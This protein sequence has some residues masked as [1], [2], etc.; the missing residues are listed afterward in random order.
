MAGRDVEALV[1]LRRRQFEEA[2]RRLAQL[3]GELARIASRI[4]A[5]KEEFGATAL[6]SS[7]SG[8]A[9]GAVAAQRRAWRALLAELE[10]RRAE[11]TA[12]REEAREALRAA[13][14]ALEQAKSLE[15]EALKR[16]LRRLNRQETAA[17][18]E[19]AAGR[20]WQLRRNAEGREL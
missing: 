20:F 4:A 11:V 16:R 12:L 2:E 1:S 10:R 17:I 13:H 19:L 8:L 3:N 9:L 7:G 15:A 14:V 5:L 18:D 6:P